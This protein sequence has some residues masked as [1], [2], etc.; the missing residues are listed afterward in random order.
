MTRIVVFVSVSVF[1]FVFVLQ[2]GSGGHHEHGMIDP[3]ATSTLALAD[4][5]T[6]IAVKT[7][8][9]DAH[10]HGSVLSQCSKNCRARRI[11]V[12]NPSK[13]MKLRV[14]SFRGI[15]ATGHRCVPNIGT[16]IQ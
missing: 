16:E 3:M 2:I 10:A 14:G 5:P 7:L 1:V 6:L 13:G 9:V 11:L 12:H 15:C 4:N 8:G